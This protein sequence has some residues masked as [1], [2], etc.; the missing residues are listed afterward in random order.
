MVRQRR[1]QRVRQR[2]APAPGR[3]PPCSRMS[4]DGGEWVLV[5]LAVFKT[6]GGP[7]GF[8]VG[9]IPTPLRHRAALHHAY[10]YG[11]RAGGTGHASSDLDIGV[12]LDPVSSVDASARFRLRLPLTSRLIGALRS[13]DVDLVVDEVPPPL[14]AAI[15]TGGVQ[16]YCRD[17]R[18]LTCVVRD[19][20]LRAADLQ[21]FLRRMERRLLERLVSS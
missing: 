12:V 21:P 15:V 8:A 11:S 5:G 7:C 17:R 16:V 9:S 10:L 13:N 18:R 4:S 3:C 1:V 19:I 6:V 14:A 20:L 2:S